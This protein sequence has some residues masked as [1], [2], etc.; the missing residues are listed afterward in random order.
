[1]LKV[2]LHTHTVD[3]PVDNIPHSTADLIDRAAALGFDALAIT[4]HD[5]QL[6]LR[7]WHAY[8]SERGVVLIPGIERTIEG[9]HV[10]LLNFDK[11]TESV[12]TFDDLAALKRRAS[13]L[14]VAPHPFFPSRTCLWRDLDRY[15]HLFD[16]VERNAM[17][18]RAVDFNRRAER[19]ATRHGKPMVG[20]GDVHRLTQLGTTYSL[21]DAEPDPA[22]ICGAIAAGRVQV[23]SQPLSWS[24][25]IPLLASLFVV[26]R[27]AGADLASVDPGARHGDSCSAPAHVGHSDLVGAGDGADCGDVARGRRHRMDAAYSRAG[28]HRNF[29]S[30][31]VASGIDA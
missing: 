13:G 15:A 23:V 25:C 20:N 10:L 24:T 26:R 28:V 11:G 31:A 6:D 27:R 1:M 30:D 29:R 4:L 2:E 5:H 19:W 16:A 18:T 14:V 9:R 22:A 8:A 12:R 17:F 3:D 7:R 21:V